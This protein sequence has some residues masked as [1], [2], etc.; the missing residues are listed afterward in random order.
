MSLLELA[1]SPKAATYVVN[2]PSSVYTAAVAAVKAAPKGTVISRTYTP[3]PLTYSA[4]L[5]LPSA[6]VV[7]DVNSGIVYGA[8]HQLDAPL[9]PIDVVGIGVMTAGAATLIIPAILGGGA[10]AATVGAGAA[11]GG[12]AATAA[13]GTGALT[14]GALTTGAILAATLPAAI[15]ST[16]KTGLGFGILDFVQKNP[17]VLAAAA[18]VGALVLFKK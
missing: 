3:A 7:A 14:T 13:V 18:I 2:A 15:A 12:A 10:A 1:G 17:W 11:G 6:T 16:A 9:R 5:A 8:T 4:A